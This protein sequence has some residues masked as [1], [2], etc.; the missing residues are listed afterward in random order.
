MMVWIKDNDGLDKIAVE[1]KRKL[2]SRF[3]L[4]ETPG[5]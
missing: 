2:L 3:W 5:L 4:F 1:V